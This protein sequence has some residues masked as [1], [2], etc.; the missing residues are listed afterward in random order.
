MSDICQQDFDS[1]QRKEIAALR[2]QLAEARREREV[3]SIIADHLAMACKDAVGAAKPEIE[4]KAKIEALKS[5]LQYPSLRPAMV[6][7]IEAEI[8]RLEKE[9][10]NA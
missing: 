9:G 2:R 8:T 3:E 6:E 7:G 10:K 4:R 5:V 1:R